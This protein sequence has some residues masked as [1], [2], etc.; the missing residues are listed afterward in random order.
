M[1][2]VKEELCTADD[3]DFA[4]DPV[5]LHGADDDYHSGS[6]SSGRQKSAATLD[7]VKVPLC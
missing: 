6:I 5:S 4:Q 1:W 3:P 2:F 7:T